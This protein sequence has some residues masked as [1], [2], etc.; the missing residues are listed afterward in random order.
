MKVLDILSAF[1]VTILV[2]NIS[3]QSGYP[4]PLGVPPCLHGGAG[5]LEQPMG[6]LQNGK[7]PKQRLFHGIKWKVLVRSC[8]LF[9]SQYWDSESW[10]DLPKTF[11]FML[12]NNLCLGSFHANWVCPLDC[13][14]I[15]APPMAI[16]TS[17]DSLEPILWLIKLTG[18]F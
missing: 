4:H 5:K 17:R 1:E 7:G 6:H 10:Q 8:Q 18:S 12:W 14:T 15:L 2:L 3:N 13:L 9:K 16:L 11:H